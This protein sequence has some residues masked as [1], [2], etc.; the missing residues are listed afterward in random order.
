M[1][2]EPD[3]SID[4]LV[5]AWSLVECAE[6][7]DDGSRRFP[8]GEDVL[9]QAVY[10]ADGRV[11]AHLQRAGRPRLRFGRLHRC[12]GRDRGRGVPDLPRLFRKLRRRQERRHGDALHRRRVVSQSREHGQVRKVRVE[13]GCLTLEATTPWASSAMSGGGP[14]AALDRWW[15]RKVAP[16]LCGSW[17]Q[18]EQAIRVCKMATLEDIEKAVA[19]LPADEFVR[20]RAWFEEF[21]ALH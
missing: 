7:L 16:L 6:I 1:P 9:G 17:L 13:E 3:Q 4:F 12:A 19:E 10:T 11:S 18:I 21:E 15:A 5:G 2:R 14:E 8:L 20:F